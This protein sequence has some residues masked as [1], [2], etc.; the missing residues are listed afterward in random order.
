MNEYESKL[1]RRQMRLVG[2]AKLLDKEY[3]D[4]I[5][6][7][8]DKYL[9][10]LRKLLDTMT[11]RDKLYFQQNKTTTRSVKLRELLDNWAKEYRDI[12]KSDMA[13]A[14]DSVYEVERK[15]I[16]EIS[17][18]EKVKEVKKPPRLVLGTTVA[19]TAAT[20][21]TRWR[22]FVDN[23]TKQGFSNDYDVYQLIAGTAKVRQRDGALFTRNRSARAHLQNAVMTGGN[24]GTITAYQEMDVRNLKWMATLDGRTCMQCASLDGKV[25]KMGDYLAWPPLHNSC[26]CKVVEDFGDT[27]IQRGALEDK[28]L[29]RPDNPERVDPYLVKGNTKFKDW[30]PTTSEEFQKEYL[31]PTRYKLYKEGKYKIENFT[32]R[33]GRLYTLEELGVQSGRSVFTAPVKF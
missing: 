24:D 7:V 15:A 8:D 13:M 2:H 20:S 19:A 17:P 3:R 12:L 14:Y 5:Q 26:R 23:K 25:F 18:H 27:D 21:A 32:D 29:K 30:L 10:R 33:H 16:L 11:E 6:R 31:G 28:E 1:I 22:K 4:K 9:A